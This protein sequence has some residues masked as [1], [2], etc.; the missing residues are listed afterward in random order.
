M[1]VDIPLNKDANSIQ[2]NLQMND[3]FVGFGFV[4]EMI[5]LSIQIFNKTDNYEKLIKEIEASVWLWIAVT[6]ITQW[7]V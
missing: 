5:F 7:V 4:H 3:N 2:S 6:M 1:K